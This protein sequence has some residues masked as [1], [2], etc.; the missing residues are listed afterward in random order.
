MLKTAGK[1]ILF[2]LNELG[3]VRMDACENA[4]I[5]NKSMKS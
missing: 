5:Y 3:E 1:K 2:Q 4:H